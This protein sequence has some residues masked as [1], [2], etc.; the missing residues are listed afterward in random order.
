M[1]RINGGVSFH[2]ERIHSQDVTSLAEQ[3]EGVINHGKNGCW[4]CAS[5]PILRSSVLLH[6]GELTGLFCG[7]GVACVPSS[8]YDFR[9]KTID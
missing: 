5:V 2:F 8:K 7:S 1:G 6:G 3:M 4:C 9:T